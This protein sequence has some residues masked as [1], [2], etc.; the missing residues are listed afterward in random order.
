MSEEITTDS[1]ISDTETGMELL[2]SETL[3]HNHSA[4]CWDFNKTWDEL[5]H[6]ETHYSSDTAGKKT[7]NTVTVFLCV[8]V[9]VRAHA[10]TQCMCKEAGRHADWQSEEDFLS[11][12]QWEA[13]PPPVCP[14]LSV[15]LPVVCLSHYL[16]NLTCSV[17]EPFQQDWA[18]R[19]NRSFIPSSPR[20]NVRWV[21]ESFPVVFS[22]LSF[23]LIAL[24]SSPK[25]EQNWPIKQL[26][27]RV[28]VLHCFE[29]S[30]AGCF[31]KAFW[32]ISNQNSIQLFHYPFFS[33]MIWKG[34]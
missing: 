17:S 8:H 6:K 27:L 23:F 13:N 10:C 29:P 1:C 21:I 22:L 20:L 31:L 12:A 2:K 32:R 30:S 34:K 28:C 25:N 24:A 14:H 18:Q 11:V 7:V 33:Y 19:I 15:S 16:I 9:Y 3:H 5:Q 4:R 26:W